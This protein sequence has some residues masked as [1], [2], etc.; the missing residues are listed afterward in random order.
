MTDAI[1]SDGLKSVTIKRKSKKKAG[2]E[3]EKREEDGFYYITKVPKN[4]ID[5]A[6]GDRVLEING[7]MHEDFKSQTN[8]NDLVD[9]LKLDV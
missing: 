6:V 9:S 2:F 5:I 8:A 4:C 7:T 1:G 3:V